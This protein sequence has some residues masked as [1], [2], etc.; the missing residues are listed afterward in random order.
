[1]TPAACRRAI[2][3]LKVLV[4]VCRAEAGKLEIDSPEYERLLD[5]ALRAEILRCNL[6]N[7]L[8]GHTV[9]GVRFSQEEL[10]A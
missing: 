8:N 4:R 2:P 1:M 5:V 9:D 6:I 10:C 3:L 7:L